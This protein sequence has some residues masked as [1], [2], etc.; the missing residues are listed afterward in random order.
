MAGIVSL[1]F[2]A[3]SSFGSLL[4]II[5]VF[6]TF[7]IPLIA[8]LD[9]V[10]IGLVKKTGQVYGRQRLWGSIGFIVSSFGLGQIVSVSNLDLDLPNQCRVFGHRLRRV[11]S[12]ASSGTIYT[13][14][15][16]S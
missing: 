5:I 13:N 12:A 8:I 10:V 9:S 11:K 7:Q 2:P 3:V 4:L 6:Y 1:F 15:P 14:N 16:H